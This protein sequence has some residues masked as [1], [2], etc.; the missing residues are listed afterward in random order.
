MYEERRQ[1][2][3]IVVNNSMLLFSSLLAFLGLGLIGN[4]LVEGDERVWRGM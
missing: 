1:V 2:T 4:I 3:T